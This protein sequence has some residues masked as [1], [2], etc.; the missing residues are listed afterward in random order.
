MQLTRV[1]ASLLLTFLVPCGAFAQGSL[2][3][4][5]PPAPAMKALDQIEPRTDLSKVAGDADFHHVISQPGSYYLTR[6]LEVTLPHGIA[7]RASGVIL[8]LN[9]FEIRRTSGAGGRGIEIDGTARRCTVK[10]GSVSGFER[11]VDANP[12]FDRAR[13]G[14]YLDVVVSN[15]SVVGLLAGESWLVERCQALENGSTGILAFFDTTIKNCTAFRN[16]GDGMAAAG[17]VTFI[18]SRSSGNGGNGITGSGFSSVVDCAAFAN[19]GGGI[20]VSVGGTITNSTSYGN[21]AFGFFVGTGSAILSST[22]RQNGTHG[23]HA[24]VETRITDCTLT[25]NAVHGIFATF[26]RVSVVRSTASLNGGSGSVGS[27]ISGGIRMDVKDCKAIENRLHGISVAG[28]STVIGNHASLNGQGAAAAGIRTAG[29]GSRIDGNH[30]RDN[31]GT[32]ILADPNDVVVRNTAGNNS[33]ANYN[34][35]SGTNFG[36]IQAPSGSN[37]PMANVQY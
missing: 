27:G 10:N 33:A 6:N 1:G 30:V 7:V 3:P 37:N 26:G 24:E 23:V 15:C 31:I 35:S 13:G 5:G 32:G 22:A 36:F 28:D 12:G 14:T 9:G 17:G 20:A 21:T 29:S 11:G 16:G 18:G 2:N 8:D 19:T 25:N 4:P 34:P